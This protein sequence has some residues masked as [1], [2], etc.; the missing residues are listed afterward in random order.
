MNIFVGNL[1]YQATEED[2]QKA[3]S[4]FGNVTSTKIIM[5]NYSGRSRGFAF[6]EMSDDAQAAQAIEKLNNTLM[7]QTAMTVNEARPRADRDRRD[8]PRRS[9]NN[10]Y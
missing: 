8:A 10:R 5:D 3:F 7:F 9:F 6:V 1:S 2:L 4:Q